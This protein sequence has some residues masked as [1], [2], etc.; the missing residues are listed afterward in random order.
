MLLGKKGV[1]YGLTIPKQNKQ[2]KPTPTGPIKAFATDGSDEEGDN[3]VG[4]QVAR[5][6]ATKQSDAKVYLSWKAYADSGG[7]QL[8]T[9]VEKSSL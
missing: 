7:F 4:V 8:E 1:K 9:A 6:A 3:S 2:Q 5:H